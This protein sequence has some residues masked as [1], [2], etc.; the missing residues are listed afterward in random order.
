MADAPQEPA[1]A[2]LR[3]RLSIPVARVFRDIGTSLAAKFA[4][5]AGFS[6]V[7][8]ARLEADV[9][10][11]ADQLAGAA[12]DGANLDLELEHESASGV[13][14]RIRRAGGEPEIVRLSPRP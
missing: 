12:G 2:P 5:T 10:R 6:D 1:A 7:E 3:L 14:V 4:R 13:E 9:A 11:A 8:A